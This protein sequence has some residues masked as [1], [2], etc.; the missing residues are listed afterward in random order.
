MESIKDADVNGKR[1]LVRVD[2]NVPLDEQH[3]ITDDLRIQKTLPTIRYILDN[4]GSAILMSHMGRPK[5]KYDDNLSLKH[6]IDHLQSSLDTDVKF[7]PDCIGEE[8]SGL[9]RNLNSGELLLLEN[10]RFHKGEKKGDEGFARKLADLADIYV[11]DAFGA[12]HR[13]HSSVSIVPK[14]FNKKYAGL[15]LQKEVEVL[16]NGFQNGKPPKTL[17]LGGAKIG[18]KIDLIKNLLD[19][20]DNILIGGAMAFTFIKSNNGN[21]GDSKIEED[22]LEVA[23]EIQ[24]VA[25]E[26]NVNFYLPEDAVV[27][28]NISDPKVVEVVPAGEIEE[29]RTGVDIGPK[30]R[31]TYSGVI[32]TSKTLIWN[33]PMGYYEKDR[34]ATGTKLVAEDIA[35]ASQ[36]GAY[37]IVGGGDT[38]VAV[39]NIN[40]QNDIFYVSTGGGAMLQFLSGK[41]LPGIEALN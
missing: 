15:L 20:V 17:V 39:K 13:A 14:Y 3:K 30:A 25:E 26:K 9:A 28:N 38:T 35:T 27:T 29:G 7:A 18:D 36:N 6:L 11:N 2:F 5:G 32:E 33:G 16:S 4:G 23:R 41:K 22:K 37:S 1:V 24:Q 21:V 12:A 40:V 31:D 19:K 8:A 34:F 10:L